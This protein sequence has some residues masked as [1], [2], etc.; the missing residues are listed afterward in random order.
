MH[1][2]LSENS[3]I[4]AVSALKLRVVNHSYLKKLKEVKVLGHWSTYK[5]SEVQ[6][7]FWCFVNKGNF[8][9]VRPADQRPRSVEVRFH[10]RC[11]IMKSRVNTLARKIKLAIAVS[12]DPSIIFYSLDPM[13]S[14]KYFTL[15]RFSFSVLKSIFHF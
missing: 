14:T 7:Y 12:V 6:T 10:S 2:S 5:F 15:F 11:Y 4:T 8:L 13:V 9:S 3:F 1:V